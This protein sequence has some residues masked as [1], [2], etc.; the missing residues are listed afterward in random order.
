[1]VR[2]EI[3]NQIKHLK[4]DRRLIRRVIQWIMRQTNIKTGEVSVAIVDDPTMAALHGRYLNDPAPTDVLSFVLETGPEHL[5]GEVVVSY[6]TAVAKAKELRVSV[7]SELLLYIVHG[8]LHLVGY[9]DIT[10]ALRR[11][12]RAA[13]KHVFEAL[14]IPY[15]GPEENSKKNRGRACEAKKRR[16]TDSKS[17]KG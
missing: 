12:M 5:E 16:R 11:K 13:E 6:D 4:L 8:T 9:D 14:R 10:P 3:A 17:G 1:L 15:P 2:I 7:A